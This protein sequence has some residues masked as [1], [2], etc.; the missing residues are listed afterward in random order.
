MGQS[1]KNSETAYSFGWAHTHA[2]FPTSFPLLQQCILEYLIPVADPQSVFVC[3]HACRHVC[4]ALCLSL[5]LIEN[6]FIRR[7][8]FEYFL[9]YKI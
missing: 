7:Y 3:V 4:V 2:V 1:A 6:C 5:S 9:F 8:T